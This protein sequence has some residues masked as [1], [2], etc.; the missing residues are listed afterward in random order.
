MSADHSIKPT[1]LAKTRR[2][3]LSIALGLL[4]ALLGIAALW[5]ALQRQTGDA[6][7]ARQNAVDQHAQKVDLAEQVK[8]ACQQG[9]AGR[10][11]LGELCQEATRIVRGDPGPAGPAGLDG[12]NGIN[13]TNGAAGN[14]GANGTDGTNGKNGAAGAPGA[15]GVAGAPGKDGTDGA[16][17]PPGPKGDPGADGTN[18]TNGK[19]GAPAYPFVFTF[20]FSVPELVGGATYQCQV[21]FD[22]AGNQDP[23]PAGCQQV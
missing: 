9:G 12:T 16:P 23:S 10:I 18:G 20:Q 6:T 3:R 11:R 15:D 19:D 22:A 7:D 4:A 8:S 14:P 1:R 13:G 5:V 2:D 17:G 21:R